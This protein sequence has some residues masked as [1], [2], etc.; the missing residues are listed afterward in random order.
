[1][2]GGTRKADSALPAPSNIRHFPYTVMIVTTNTWICRHIHIYIY[3]GMPQSKHKKKASCVYIIPHSRTG[4]V[5]HTMYEH[6]YLWLGCKG[7]NLQLGRFTLSTPGLSQRH[8][9][10]HVQLIFVHSFASSQG[11]RRRYIIQGSVPEPKRCQLIAYL[12]GTNI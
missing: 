4:L 9:V 12:T 6:T 5:Y 8:G 7:A 2:G 1:M 3:I 11:R 10:G